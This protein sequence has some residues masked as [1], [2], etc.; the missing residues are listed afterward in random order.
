MSRS[1]RQS[2]GHFGVAAS[3]RSEDRDAKEDYW[4]SLASG[5]YRAL[6]HLLQVKVWRRRAARGRNHDSSTGSLDFFFFNVICR[7]FS[8]LRPSLEPLL[9]SASWSSASR[10]Q[11]ARNR[12]WRHVVQL[13]TFGLVV[14]C[15]SS[16][17]FFRS[18]Q[19]QKLYG[20]CCFI[21]VSP[22]E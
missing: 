12:R 6:R 17:V 13:S 20:L 4:R 8:F 21:L 5:L 11:C 2:V 3:E 9:S 7:V 18:P 1:A 22:C 10:C 19:H 16:C 15:L 14:A